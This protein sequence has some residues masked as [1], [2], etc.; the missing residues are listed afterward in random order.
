M[1]KI[2]LTTLLLLSFFPLIVRAGTILEDILKKIK[3]E[4]FTAGEFLAGVFMIIGG[5]QMITAAGDPQKFENGKKTLLFA[6]IGLLVV[7]LADKIVE[8][9]KT[10]K[11]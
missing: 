8:W 6:G 10:F 7:L 2:I 4:L 5:Y 9:L 11:R 1:K 3:D